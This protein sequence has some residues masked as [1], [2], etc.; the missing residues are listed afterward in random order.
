MR[1][2]GALLLMLAGCYGPSVAVGLPCSP[3][4]ECPEGQECAPDGTCQLP[5]APGDDDAGPGDRD[6]TPG[7]PDAMPI[8]LES[9]LVSFQH[10]SL[11]R[12]ANVARIAG[13]YALI[14]NSGQVIAIDPLGSIRWQRDYAVAGGGFTSAVAS[15]TGGM[16]VAGTNGSSMAAF[17]VD[18]DGDLRW[19]KSYA[20]QDESSP[21]AVVDLPNTDDVM[22]VANSR[23]GSDV[24][25]P[26]LV[27]VDGEGEIVWQ[28][29]YTLAGGATIHGGTPAG[30]GGFVAVGVSD[31]ATPD[32]RDVIAFK[33][34]AAGTL[35]WSKRIDGGA[36]E[37]GESVVEDFDGHLALVGGTWSGSF[38]L[39]D[40]WLIRLDANGGIQSQH[41]IGSTAQ[42][43][44]TRVRPLGPDGAVLVGE[45]GAEGNTDLVAIE[46]KN[47][48]ITT[49]Q[50]IGTGEGD[51]EA[52]AAFDD[53]GV[54]VLGD[55]GAFGEQIGF[56]AAG[57]LL[58][59]GLESCP[60]GNTADLD[61][62]ASTATASSISLTV[63]T[64]TSPA[65][66]V[67]VTATNTTVGITAECE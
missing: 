64:T 59:A 31:A 34:D 26:W 1:F 55:T 32:E 46:L 51:Y 37:W 4:G 10:P 3:E 36:N 66:D 25:S 24:P 50:L 5:G 57:V 43:T 35:V 65:T 61:I 27:R 2:A 41:R 38:G 17:A 13:G 16:L 39:A 18:H 63:T 28:K 42:D 53:G 54:V 23:D 30:N 20:D 49:Q 52:G 22:L 67:D 6:A 44:G 21:Q 12:A 14:G 47:D 60:H 9:W 11:A 15:V 56:F 45:T 19:Q 48:V 29:R 62:A 33:V 7:T 8:P 40:I 58:P